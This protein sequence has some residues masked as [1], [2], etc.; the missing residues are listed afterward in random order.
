VFDGQLGDRVKS[1]G[2][3]ILVHFRP[4]DAAWAN[5][6]DLS[7]FA[8]A[9]VAAS[10]FPAQGLFIGLAVTGVAYVMSSS[11][12][13]VAGLALTVVLMLVERLMRRDFL[14]PTH[15]VRE[16]GLVW[17]SRFALALKRVEWVKVSPPRFG[18][19]FD[20]AN[21]EV[22]YHGGLL[23]L[24]CVAGAYEKA[25]IIKAAVEAIRK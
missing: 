14:T 13:V 16:A 17:R 4:S 11:G 9:Q 15:I 20:A 5:A 3:E 10:F 12:G 6:L 7:G 21:I 23:L 19:T 24:P 22:R 1:S 25:E 18:S 2:E 8:F